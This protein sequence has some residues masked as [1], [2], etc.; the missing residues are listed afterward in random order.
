M[1]NIFFI[2]ATTF[3]G[4]LV[5][6]CGSEAEPFIADQPP[7]NPQDSV[8]MM[9]LYSAFH[10]Q[11]I[12]DPDLVWVIRHPDFWKGVEFEYDETTGYRYVSQVYLWGIPKYIPTSLGELT[13]LKGLSLGNVPY[14]ELLVPKEIFNCPLEML[15]INGCQPVEKRAQLERVTL[16]SEIVKVKNTLKKV[17]IRMTEL[18]ELPSEFGQLTKLEECIL[19][20]NKLVGPVPDYFGDFNCEVNLS[21]NL[22]TEYNWNLILQGKNV[23]FCKFNYISNP[24]PEEVKSNYMHIIREKFLEGNK[25]LGKFL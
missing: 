14:Q 9:E 25:E 12:G 1:K 8:I 10:I 20:G 11:E 19:T 13:H 22:F 6:A 2:L 5:P 7:L 4:M 24:I 15:Y 16:P 17:M 18:T 21:D 3:L 23:P